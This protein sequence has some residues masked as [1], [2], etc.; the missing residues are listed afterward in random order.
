LP[1]DFKREVKAKI[2]AHTEWLRGRDPSL[3]AIASEFDALSRY[4]CEEDHTELLPE[5]RKFCLQMDESRKENTLAV[6]PE[7]VS[8]L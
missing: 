6:F 8:V 7:L 4:M 3:E 5:F 2:E 1:A